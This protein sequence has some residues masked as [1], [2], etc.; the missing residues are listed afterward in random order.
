MFKHILS[1]T[2]ITACLAGPVGAQATPPAN[3]ATAPDATQGAATPEN[4]CM[5]SAFE[6][7]EAAEKKQL[8]DSSLEKLDAMFT[9]LEGHCNAQQMAEAKTVATEIK[10]LI[11]SIN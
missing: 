6:L 7:A 9:K 3:M 4:E 2:F 5:K 8:P 1:A 10:T 11:D